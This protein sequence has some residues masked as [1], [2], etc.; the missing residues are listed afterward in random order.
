M[1]TF[2]ENMEGFTR[3]KIKGAK[4]AILGL[5]KVGYPSD[6]DNKNMINSNMISNFPVTATDINSAH[7]IFGRNVSILKQK[8][9]REQPP[10]VTSEYIAIPKHIRDITQRI[11]VAADVM[12]LNGLAFMVSVSHGLKFTTLEYMP[13]QTAPVLSQSLENIYELYSKCG[14]TV[15]LFLMDWEFK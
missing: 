4:E 14:F 7:K 15:E 6:T 12:L 8:T 3:R 5:A 2:R 1:N 10:L 13:R 9:V 11:T